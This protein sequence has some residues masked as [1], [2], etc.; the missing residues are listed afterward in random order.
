M[1]QSIIQ[2]GANERRASFIARYT[3]MHPTERPIGSLMAAAQ[4]YDA[5][6]LMLRTLFQTRGNTQG[7]VLKAA[8]ENL[9]EP[10]RGVVTT[11]DRPF[12]PD[13]HDAFSDRMIW[14]GEWRNGRIVYH[15]PEDTK[16]SSVLRRKAE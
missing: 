15:Y 4:S 9:Q 5:V 8:L 3:R 6:H 10:Y 2:D 11:F 16:L 7:P 1:A 12:T 14:L 13:D